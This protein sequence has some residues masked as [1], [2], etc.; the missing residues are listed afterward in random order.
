ML[1]GTLAHAVAGGVGAVPD[2]MHRRAD[3][4]CSA[5][6]RAFSE[7]RYSAVNFSRLVLLKLDHC[8]LSSSVVDQCGGRF[9]AGLPTGP[10]GNLSGF[11]GAKP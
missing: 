11:V 3:E 5:A 1:S 8:F 10:G 6:R 7:L 4:S 9:R 2:K